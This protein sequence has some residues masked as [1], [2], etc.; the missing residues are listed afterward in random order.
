MLSMGTNI[1]IDSVM[2]PGSS[3]R[4]RKKVPQL[5]LQLQLRLCTL[6]Y[7]SLRIAVMICETLVNTQTHN[8]ALNQ[9]FS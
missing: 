4:E 9:V 5:Q 3:S 7:K 2:R 6:A 8:T 1:R